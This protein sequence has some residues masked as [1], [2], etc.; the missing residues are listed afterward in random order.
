[1]GLF[2]WLYITVLSKINSW[3]KCLQCYKCYLILCLLN[4][5][6]ST[7]KM[8]SILKIFISFSILCLIF[9]VYF[10]KPEFISGIKITDWI[11]ALCNVLMAG[12]A[13]GGFWIAKNWQKQKM[14][15]DAYQLSKKIVLNNYRNIV[16]VYSDLYGRL[17]YYSV[18]ISSLP[19]RGKEH[20]PGIEEVYQ[21]KNKLNTVYHLRRELEDNFLYIEKLGWKFKDDLLAYDKD[22][23]D[24]A[25]GDLYQFTKCAFYTIE[26]IILK[27]KSEEL[28]GLAKDKSDYLEYL[29]KIKHEQGLLDAKYN[30][31]KSYS[32]KVNGYFNIE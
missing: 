14:D 4:L 29:K 5:I 19:R 25:F 16:I 1:M 28:E 30:Y 10:S 24:L 15:E 31:F 17:D 11:S 22:F 27:I 9:I 13:F 3:Y 32:K 20:L 8:S 18:F 2:L 23:N 12:A 6:G 26:S 21:F 7:T